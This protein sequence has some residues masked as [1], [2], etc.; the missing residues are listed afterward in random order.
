[1]ADMA[2]P[3]APPPGGPGT[4][5]TPLPAAAGE[6]PDAPRAG[7]PGDGLKTAAIGKADSAAAG[8]HGSGGGANGGAPRSG[9]ATAGA[10][11]AATGA[12]SGAAAAGAAADLVTG[13]DLEAMLAQIGM[14]TRIM[15]RAADGAAIGPANPYYRAE[16]LAVDRAQRAL[17]LRF[18]Y[19]GD[20]APFWLPVASARLWR[21]AY[22]LSEAAWTNLGKVR[23]REE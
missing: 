19:F 12:G 23:G 5:S 6:L 1:M 9:A 2:P 16:V 3:E 15:V 20:R 18:Q 21:G 8:K 17:Q 4:Q 11:A 22:P 10:A 7:G 13:P 14:P